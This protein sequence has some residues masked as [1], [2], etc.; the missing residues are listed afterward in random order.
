MLTG[1]HNHIIV[2]YHTFFDDDDNLW[3]R[4]VKLK[5]REKKIE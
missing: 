1:F 2:A 4:I 5:K 3:S